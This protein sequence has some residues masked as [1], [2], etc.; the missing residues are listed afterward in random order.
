M[1]SDAAE[2]ALRHIEI[3]TPFLRRHITE[4]AQHPD[5]G[6]RDQAYATVRQVQDALTTLKNFLTTRKRVNPI[7]FYREKYRQ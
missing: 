4:F 1:N 5:P 7:V 2:R 3:H 6:H